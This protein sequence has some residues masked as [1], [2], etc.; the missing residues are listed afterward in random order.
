M[1][2][3]KRTL[4]ASIL[5]GV[6]GVV[7][8]SG[9][10]VYRITRSEF[11]ARFDAT[12][13]ERARS[14]ATML[15][16]E[17][18]GLEFELENTVTEAEHGAW[19]RVSTDHG[20]I[21]ATSPGWPQNDSPAA[22][23]SDDAARFRTRLL[24]NE[25]P[26]RLVTLTIRVPYDLDDMPPGTPPLS[27]R[28]VTI[29]LMERLDDVFEAETAVLIAVVL[30][31][32]GAVAGSFIAVWLGVQ[33]GLAP[34]RDLGDAV[35]RISP[36]QLQWSAPATR[37]PRE[38][39]PITDAL[40]QMLERTRRAMARERRFTDAA[41][42][43][44]RTPL[45]ELKIITDVSDR[46]PEPERLRRGVTD[47]RRV[48]RHMEDLLEC[49]LMLARGTA[50]DTR[51]V[52][53]VALL[54]LVRTLADETRTHAP[55]DDVT[56][57]IDGDE[58]A[59]WHGSAAAVTA[60][61][62][63]LIENAAQY[64]PPGGHVHIHAA[65]NGHGGMLTIENGPVELARDELDRMF[66]PFWQADPARTDAAHRGL[67]LAIVDALAEALRFRREAALTEASH[68]RITVTDR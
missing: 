44:L 47:A 4:L 53:D 14:F 28:R 62:R 21:L 23:G 57:H 52:T 17:E 68:L 29:E 45:A 40:E 49:L 39:L 7:V 11:R 13:L 51:D 43:E 50:C 19:I 18:D 33:R 2:S 27:D 35:D 38:L 65:S 9:I 24:E 12:L 25:T 59:H 32:A 64:T 56:W 63:N 5:C 30:G 41:A 26:V 31:G 42:H 15:I 37:Y 3:L 67:G 1:R 61:V 10:S 20:D 58:A 8:L 34:V 46:W 22:I 48:V 54:P 6:T 66:E 55:S 60:I 16:I 36:Q